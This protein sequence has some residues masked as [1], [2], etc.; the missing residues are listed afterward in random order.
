[1]TSA[2]INIYNISKILNICIELAQNYSMDKSNL[3]GMFFCYNK[4]FPQLSISTLETCRHNRKV[5]ESFGRNDLIQ[6]WHLAEMIASPS[7]ESDGDVFHQNPFKRKM[8][9]SLYVYISNFITTSVI[10]CV[11]HTELYI[12]PKITTFKQL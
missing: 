1:M 3:M 2:T 10:L 11:S 9:E 12:M 8:L 7:E 5:A 6:V 4:F